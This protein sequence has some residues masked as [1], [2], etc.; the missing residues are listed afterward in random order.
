MKKGLSEII[1][2]LDR[3]TSMGSIIAEAKDGFKQFLE[4]QRKEEGEAFLT[5]AYFD[6][7]YDKVIDHKNLKDVD[8]DYIISKY[9]PRG[10]TALNDAIGNTV[11]DINKRL[12][13][14]EDSERP[15]NFVFVIL[16]DGDENASGKFST[17]KVNE[18][19]KNQTEKFGWKFV[20]L[21]SNI[22]AEKTASTYGIDRKHAYNFSHTGDGVTRGMTSLAC[23][24]TSYRKGVDMNL[25]DM[26]EE[27]FK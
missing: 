7:E 14:T 1:C 25:N 9:T 21:A 12:N 17:G 11:N 5:V 13:E 2:V 23:A 10:M 4:T 24:T 15:E 6:S 16:T 27:K 20:F 8:D 22:N 19:I 26:Q 3:S 18:I